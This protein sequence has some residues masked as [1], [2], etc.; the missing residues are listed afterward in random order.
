LNKETVRVKEGDKVISGDLIGFAGN[1]GN[2][3]WPHLHLHIQNQPELNSSGAKGIPFRFKMAEVKR[4]FDFERQSDFYP[5]RNDL[6]K[7]LR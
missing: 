1:S 3:S 4:W 2:T 6:I 5:L 7:P